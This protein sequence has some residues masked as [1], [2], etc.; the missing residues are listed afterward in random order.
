M[1]FKECFTI[2]NHK[3]NLVA[4]TWLKRL[5]NLYMTQRYSMP[6]YLRLTE[7][8]YSKYKN[9]NSRLSLIVSQYFKRKNETINQF[10]HGYEHNI[11]YGTLFHH[12]G[13]TLPGKTTINENVQIFKNVTLALVDG[14]E[15]EIG[16]NS[17]IFSHVIVLGKKIGKNCVIGAGSVVIHDILDNS[18]V[19]GNPA[20]VI[21]KSKNSHAYWKNNKELTIWSMEPTAKN[22]TNYKNIIELVKNNLVLKKLLKP[23]Y[24]NL[25]KPFISKEAIN[26]ISP[27]SN[28][29]NYL[30]KTNKYE[31]IGAGLLSKDGHNS[32]SK[33]KNTILNDSYDDK[34]GYRH[35]ELLDV[36][37]N[38]LTKIG[39]FYSTYNSCGYRADLHARFSLDEKY[40]QIDS[41]HQERRKQ[42]I[43]KVEN[44]EHV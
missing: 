2:D 4:K 8:F 18:I 3:Y 44:V 7:Y 19:V 14:K 13:V 6:V 5:Y 32:W 37:K 11:A 24:R 31:I 33:D 34:A 27:A 36:K 40:I 21:K 28:L 43:L 25:V 35:L 30:D 42:I 17:V 29:I 41:A 38:K 10:E 20:R 12:N 16:E 39:K 26:I 9:N 1:T 23:I 15:C 22:T